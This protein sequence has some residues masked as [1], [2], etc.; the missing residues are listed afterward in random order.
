MDKN[1]SVYQNTLKL[2]NLDLLK[3][4]YALTKLFCKFM[5]YINNHATSGF[6]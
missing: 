1:K 5:T 6:Y 2:D 4:L 3:K